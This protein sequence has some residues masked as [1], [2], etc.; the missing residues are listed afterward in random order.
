MTK[1][2]NKIKIS[3]KLAEAILL[4]R[5]AEDPTPCEQ[6]KIG[7]SLYS[8]KPKQ[9]VVLKMEKHKSEFLQSGTAY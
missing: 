3:V 7:K 8:L 4:H 9:D 6:D 2:Q 1:K 5:E